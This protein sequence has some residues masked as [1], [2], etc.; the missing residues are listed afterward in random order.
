MFSTLVSEDVFEKSPAFMAVLLGDD[1]IFSEANERYR[2]ITG[3][4]DILGKSVLEALPE[5]KGQGFLE[6][7]Q[8][9]YRTGEIFE[10]NEL[11]VNLI[12]SDDPNPKQ[13]FLNF[14]YRRINDSSGAPVGIFVFG[15]DVTELVNSRK[16]IEESEVQ[17]R[18]FIDSMPQMAFIA[19]PNGDI[20][21]FNQPWYE[22]VKGLEGTEGWG[23]QD[24]PVHHPDDLYRTIERW[25][26]SLETGE[27]Y[28]I[29]YRLRRFDGVYRWHLGRATPVRDSQGQ[30]IRWVGTNTDIHDHKETQAKLAEA[31][32]SRDEFLSIA[33]HELKTP[34]TALHLQGEIFK[35]AAKKNNEAM[36]K[37]ER[38]LM[39][40]EQTEKQISRIG[41]LV[42]DMLDVSRISFGKLTINVSKFDM[43]DLVKECVERFAPQFESHGF[44]VPL[45]EVNT[46]IVTV[47]D[48]ARI[49]QVLSNLLSNA[50][51][52]GNKN[53]VTISLIKNVNN[54]EL[55]VTDFGIGIPQ[56]QIDRIFDKFER[57]ID[58]HDISG[59][60]LGLYISKTIVEAHGGTISAES[61]HGSGSTFR[62]SLPYSATA[63]SSIIGR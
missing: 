16:K 21:Y 39:M 60:G 50:I 24:K 8:N 18:L 61:T 58:K 1:F 53:P 5:L 49:D 42:D 63:S 29:E 4:R 31:V 17:F 43:S 45:L 57:A 22:Y 55:K 32:K 48:K 11:P 19:S 6:I 30:I 36:F 15:I 12:T 26:H 37:K 41:K 25:K 23:W 47:G 2:N 27:P 14:I 56:D 35:R 44:P 59:L 34:L 7:L 52:Y 51:R 28:E 40:M 3:N 33:S 10:G 54:V 38:V 9:V 46:G 13:L 62:I 20:T